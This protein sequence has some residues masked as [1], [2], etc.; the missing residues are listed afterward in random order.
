MITRV[1]G[2]VNIDDLPFESPFVPCPDCYDSECNWWYFIVYG[3]FTNSCKDSHGAFSCPVSP[4]NKNR[5]VGC[6]E[7]KGL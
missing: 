4:A 5:K 3:K 1:S 6:F 7:A 2:N